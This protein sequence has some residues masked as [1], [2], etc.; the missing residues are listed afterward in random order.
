MAQL[1]ANMVFHRQQDALRRSPIRNRTWS[2][3]S[4]TTHTTASGKS[5]SL[6]QASPT[7]PLR[8]MILP[9][10]LDS[11]SDGEEDAEGGTSVLDSPLQLSPLCLSLCRS[12]ENFYAQLEGTTAV[13]LSTS[14]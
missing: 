11:N 5:R 1:V 4:S 2:P 10:D 3:V 6:T 13:P 14:K 9:E 8:Q 7:S 12:P